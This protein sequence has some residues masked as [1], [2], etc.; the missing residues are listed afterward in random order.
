MP[1][2]K[3]C[4]AEGVEHVLVQLVLRL[5]LRPAFPLF[6]LLQL[7]ELAPGADVH[8]LLVALLEDL[9][10]AR[11]GIL[12][13]LLHHTPLLAVPRERVRPHVHDNVLLLVRTDLLRPLEGLQFEG[14]GL[15]V[16]L[17]ELR[18]VRPD[19][20]PLVLVDDSQP[21]LRPDVVDRGH[22]GL[23][24]SPCLL[25]SFHHLDLVRPLLLV[26]LALG[27]LLARTAPQ[28]Q[29]GPRARPLLRLLLLPPLPLP[30]RRESLPGGEARGL[31]VRVGLRALVWSALLLALLLLLL[32]VMARAVAVLVVVVIAA[33]VLVRIAVARGVALAV[34]VAVA[35]AAATEAE[36][37]A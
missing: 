28:L 37:V 18:A 15:P 7:P 17:L 32:L 14:L 31:V 19:P 3:R 25:L 16:E 11:H 33:V 22:G 9:L 27:L 5:R 20:L 30:L 1:L 2:L 26:G 35:A 34:A 4:P 21:D 36:A 29:G 10:V 6:D 23:F 12:P 13:S 8:E 24:L